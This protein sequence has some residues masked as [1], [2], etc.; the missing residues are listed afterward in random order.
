[1]TN[2]PRGPN[3]PASREP[4]TI[5]T[6]YPKGKPQMS[7]CKATNRQGNRCGRSAVPGA[8]VCNMHGG[9]APQ[10]QAKAAERLQWA[11]QV[12]LPA[13]DIEWLLS[14]A[15]LDIDLLSEPEIDFDEVQAATD[16]LLEELV[17]FPFG[18]LYSE[19]VDAMPDPMDA[20]PVADPEDED[21]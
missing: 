7:Q 10:V 14:Q 2:Q 1:M 15:E 5:K 9:K 11:A 8:T 3:W 18:R 16:R 6:S 20:P 19:A 4:T 13:D 17:A 12:D 21:E